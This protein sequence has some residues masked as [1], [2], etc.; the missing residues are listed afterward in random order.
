MHVQILEPSLLVSDRHVVP[1]HLAFLHE[2]LCVEGPI[3]FDI[4][5][6]KSKPKTRVGSVN[7]RERYEDRERIRSAHL[8]TVTAI[9]LFGAVW[10]D[11]EEFVEELRR[12]EKEVLGIQSR[13]TSKL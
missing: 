5:F 11:E 4:A 8:K 9:P 10:V 12:G 3:L 1:A 6:I 2:A 13:V 7:Q